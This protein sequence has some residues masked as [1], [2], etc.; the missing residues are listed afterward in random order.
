MAT[1]W[2]LV[3]AVQS[4]HLQQQQYAAGPYIP[5]LTVD[6]AAYG[7]TRWPAQGASLY[8]APLMLPP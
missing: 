5:L 8:G 3:T 1:L 4:L 2:D 7:H 6:A